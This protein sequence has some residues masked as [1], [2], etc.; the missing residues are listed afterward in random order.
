MPYVEKDV[1]TNE[2]YMDELK[3]L[4]GRF[5][6][7]ALVIDGETLLGFGMNMARVRELLQQ[8]GYLEAA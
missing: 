7:P 4:V 2:Q 8:G 6:T 3:E 1:T 5:A